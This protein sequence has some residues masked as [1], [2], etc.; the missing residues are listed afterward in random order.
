VVS[1]P[2][3]DI[4]HKAF[5]QVDELELVADLQHAVE[6][7]FGHDLAERAASRRIGGGMVNPRRWCLPQVIG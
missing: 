5:L 3:G 6:F 2:P 7:L 4:G 1:Q